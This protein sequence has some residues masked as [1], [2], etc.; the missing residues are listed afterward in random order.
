MKSLPLRRACCLS[1]LFAWSC[2]SAPSPATPG[3]IGFDADLTGWR[4]DHTGGSGSASPWVQRADAAAV[5]PPNV[6]ALQPQ[7]VTTDERFNLFWTPEV[8][9]RNGRIA[10]AA[11]ADQGTIDQGGGPIWRAQDADNYYIC[12]F[13]PLESNY[14]VYVV[15]DGV[16]RQL[17][18][19]RVE[20]RPGQWHRIEVEHIGDRITCWLDGVPLLEATD[21]AIANEGGVGLWTKADAA[22]SFD[23]LVVTAK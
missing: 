1:V 7:N 21:G 12:R 9:F 18:T 15:K 20:T 3:A 13:N 22:T 19:A 16:R 2:S 23:D 5:S 4:A 17:A 11:R 10:V 8:R 6:V 14:R